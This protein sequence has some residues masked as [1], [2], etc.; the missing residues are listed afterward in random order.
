MSPVFKPG[1]SAPRR[2][3][4]GLAA[5]AFMLSLFS[6]PAA[7]AEWPANWL[8][9]PDNSYRVLHIG[10]HYYAWVL[11]DLPDDKG[12]S[13]LPKPPGEAMAELQAAAAELNASYAPD[14]REHVR[15]D[16]WK[17]LNPQ[18]AES[19]ATLEATQPWAAR[20]FKRLTLELGET[21]QFYWRNSRFNCALDFEYLQD[22][23]PRL[24][25]SI[26]ASDAPYYSPVGQAVY[27]DERSRYDGLL[28]IT[29]LYRYNKDGQLERV[30][31][32]GGFTWGC[33]GPKQLCGW[34]WWAAPPDWHACGSDW[35]LC[36]EFG[37]Q[38]DSLFY[39]S[40]HPEHWF[41]H[42]A[43]SEANLAR[44]GEHFD[45]MSY[46]LRRT[47]EADWLDLKW[48]A[49]RQYG[50]ADG[51]HAPDKDGWLQARGLETDPNPNHADTDGDGMSD[52][53]ELLCGNGNRNGH[54]ERLS[55]HIG[56]CDPT[57]PD[58]DADG[59]PDGADELPYVPLVGSIRQAAPGAAWLE[60]VETH[61][62]D[63]APSPTGN[64]PAAFVPGVISESDQSASPPY[65]ELSYQQDKALHLRLLWYMPDEAPSDK[66]ELRLTFDFDNDGWFAGNDNYR[67]LLDEAGVQS[68]IRNVCYSTTEG[69]TEVTDA[70]DINKIPCTAMREA[71]SPYWG[72]D[73][74][75]PHALFPELAAKAGEEFGFNL[76]IRAKPA[77][78]KRNAWFYTIYDPNALLPLELR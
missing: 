63:E 48:G 58:S 19:L 9:N 51:D 23:E 1:F 31:G 73:L 13:P 12:V 32:G 46:I 7:A 37:H 33:D 42:L 22:F 59:L 62:D 77:D 57:D 21:A 71:G 2:V 27:G 49:L 53:T 36:H 15:Y 34:S 4:G 30:T 41:N 70:V 60:A 16:L 39:A 56:Y 3:A 6:H 66:Y 18:L 69:P 55:D 26:A 5:T 78:P 8:G 45:C 20:E 75:L 14:H 64:A 40:G 74:T 50:D 67:L 10:V 17:A 76:G 35:L 43:E 11:D 29:C 38:L 28:Q 44:F 72:L 54:G 65:C 52:Y 68:V 24:R 47:K 25:S 61:P